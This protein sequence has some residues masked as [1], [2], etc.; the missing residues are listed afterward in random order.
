MVDPRVMCRK[1][2]LGEHVETHMFAGTIRKGR[3]IQGYIERGL[4]EVDKIKERHEL[5][6]NEMVRRGYR[7]KSPLQE[8]RSWRAGTVD[9]FRSILDLQKRCSECRKS[10]GGHREKRRVG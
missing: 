5:L 10:Q 7:H 4:V 2:L 3:S 6:A 1:P 9:R 8:F